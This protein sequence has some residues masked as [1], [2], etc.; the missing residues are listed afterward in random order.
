MSSYNPYLDTKIYTGHV[1]LRTEAIPQ[2][3]SFSCFKNERC[4]FFNP[5][6][7]VSFPDVI[8]ALQNNQI[9]D[10]DKTVVCLVATYGYITNRQLNDFLRLIGKEFSDNQLKSCVER[11]QKHQMIASFKFGYNEN[12]TANFYVHTLLKNGSELAKTLGITHTFSPFNVGQYPWKIKQTLAINQLQLAFLKSGLDIGWIKR[13]DVV[14]VSGCKEGVV[15]PSLAV[16]SN[17]DVIL[18]EL[19]RC[20]EFWE[21]RLTEKL[22]RYK[23]V[24]E[25]WSGNNWNVTQ[26][27]SLVICGES[28]EQNRRISEIAAEVGIH[29]LFTEDILLCGKNF[30]KSIYDLEDPDTPAYYEYTTA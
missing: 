26:D 28:I 9:T 21:Q 12:S 4:V 5:P 22:S 18:F 15:R 19:V 10:L 24:L 16:K 17:S 23:L 20:G 25:G 7:T 2:S 13:G 11:L 1:D 14:S 29:V 8:K 30:Y 27:C 6:T 3:R